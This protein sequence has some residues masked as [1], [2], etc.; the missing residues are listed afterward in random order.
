MPTTPE[1]TEFIRP[2]FTLA[3]GTALSHVLHACGNLSE[4]SG[5][6]TADELELI[7]RMEIRF[8][9]NVATAEARNY[10]RSRLS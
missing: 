5:Y 8:A 1:F 9:E 3:E 4:L 2:R 7:K 10:V 6:F